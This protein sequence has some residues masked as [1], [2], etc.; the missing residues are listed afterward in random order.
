[1]EFVEADPKKASWGDEWGVRRGCPS[2]PGKGS[3]RKIEF[4]T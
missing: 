4:L 3:G 1:M 2:S